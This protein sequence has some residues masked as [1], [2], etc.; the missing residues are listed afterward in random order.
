MTK[1]PKLIQFA[2]R[3]IHARQ[4]S[5]IDEGK[6]KVR[7]PMG[8]RRCEDGD[9]LVPV[10]NDIWCILPRDTMD[11]LIAQDKAEETEQA[12]IKRAQVLRGG[13]KT[14]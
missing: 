6:L 14:S 1:T 8:Y 11:F 7:T 12:P 3:K 10:G 5:R 9:W 13:V 4:Y 2:K